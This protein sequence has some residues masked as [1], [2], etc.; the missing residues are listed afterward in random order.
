LNDGGHFSNRYLADGESEEEE[1]QEEEEPLVSKDGIQAPAWYAKAK[2][3]AEEKQ[4]EERRLW[5]GTAPSATPGP[6]PLGPAGARLAPARKAIAQANARQKRLV[7]AFFRR[8]GAELPLLG[9]AL[10]AAHAAGSGAEP[11][12]QSDPA[13]RT[14]GTESALLRAEMLALGLSRSATSTLSD[15]GHCRLLMK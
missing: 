10:D 1:Q 15:G 3:Q 11:R 4:A 6:L 14:A 8:Y 5:N 7:Q 13:V 2:R 12:D 9:G